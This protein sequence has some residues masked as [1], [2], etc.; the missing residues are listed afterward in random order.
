MGRLQLGL[1]FLWQPFV[2]IVKKSYPF[3]SSLF[4]PGITGTTGT[5]ILWKY[6]H[7]QPGILEMI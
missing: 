1:E 5:H 4:D 3:A 7:S 2:V 6:A